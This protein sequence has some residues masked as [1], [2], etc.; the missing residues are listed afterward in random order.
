MKSRAETSATMD[1]NDKST[2]RVAVDALA[3]IRNA[4][5]GRGSASSNA[6]VVEEMGGEPGSEPTETA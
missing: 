3:P 2:V 4:R 1:E 6:A 5:L